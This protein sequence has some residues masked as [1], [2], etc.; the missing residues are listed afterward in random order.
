MATAR[1]GPPTGRAAVSAEKEKTERVNPPLGALTKSGG[2]GGGSPVGER[3]LPGAASTDRNG[4]ILPGSLPG[5]A[6]GAA[7][8]AAAAALIGPERRKLLLSSAWTIHVGPCLLPAPPGGHEAHVSLM[9]VTPCRMAIHPG[10]RADQHGSRAEGN[11]VSRGASAAESGETTLPLLSWPHEVR[12]VV[13]SHVM[14][15]LVPKDYLPGERILD[16]N[17]SDG[18]L[19]IVLHGSIVCSLDASNEGND[20]VVTRSDANLDTCGAG[21]PFDRVPGAAAAGGDSARAKADG[22][23]RR[24]DADAD[25]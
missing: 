4:S 1:G 13:A 3:M 22:Q 18:Q 25:G 23:F 19:T 6:A 17:T 16:A 2:V 8:P 7:K 14:K 20:G 11:G 12:P 5:A 21:A 15:R 10:E 9:C 24:V